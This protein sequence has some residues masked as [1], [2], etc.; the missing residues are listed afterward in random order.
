MLQL[1]GSGNRINR[2]Y[3]GSVKE[4]PSGDFAIILNSYY[5]SLLSYTNS[6]LRKI[7]TMITQQEY[8]SYS[9]ID[10][11]FLYL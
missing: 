11:N 2:I 1:L 7:S 3:I 6:V 10:I 9:D 8:T 4:V 5:C